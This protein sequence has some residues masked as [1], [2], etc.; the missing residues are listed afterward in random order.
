METKTSV[1]IPDYEIKADLNLSDA[2]DK[3][4]YLISFPK[5]QYGFTPGIANHI[6]RSIT[7]LNEI[8]ANHVAAERKTKNV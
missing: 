8:I 5:P 4:E 7:S 6:S 2:L 3:R 1:P